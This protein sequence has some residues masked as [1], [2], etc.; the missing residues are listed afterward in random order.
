MNGQLFRKQR[1]SQHPVLTFEKSVLDEHCLPYWTM[2]LSCISRHLD[3]L[4]KIFRNHARNHAHHT[5]SSHPAPLGW[6]RGWSTTCS[7]PG[8][9]SGAPFILTQTSTSAR[10]IMTPVQPSGDVWF[11]VS[12]PIGAPHSTSTLD[13][14]SSWQLGHRNRAI[15]RNQ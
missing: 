10:E 1:K 9:R 11:K 4:S 5:P 3:T 2:L 12:K 6:N 8:D 14:I 13:P 7:M 15:T